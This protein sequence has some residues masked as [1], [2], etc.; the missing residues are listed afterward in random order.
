VNAEGGQQL[1]LEA[2]EALSANASHDVSCSAPGDLV[3]SECATAEAAA[4][5]RQPDVRVSKSA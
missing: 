2:V 1:V 4:G 5:G 3:E